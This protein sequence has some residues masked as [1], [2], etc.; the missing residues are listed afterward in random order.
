MG[1]LKGIK[2][3]LPVSPLIERKTELFVR[4][5]GSKYLLKKGK[6][7]YFGFIKLILYKF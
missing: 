3:E 1:G 6:S 7:N 5:V 4:F 2:G